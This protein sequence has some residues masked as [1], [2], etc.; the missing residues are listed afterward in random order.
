MS[1][2]ERS[3]SLLLHPLLNTTTC[4]IITYTSLLII[5][6]CSPS[7]RSLIIGPAFFSAWAYTTL[8]YCIT[9][10]NPL[11]SFLAPRMYLLVF[12][13]AD[14]VS[15]VLQAIGGGQAAVAAQKGTDT[16]KATKIS[17]FDWRHRIVIPF[18]I[19]LLSL[20]GSLPLW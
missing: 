7:P 1:L 17:E 16:K 12:V 4:C 11:C 20:R 19:R 6:L 18:Q 15:L 14:I 3:A 2:I 8:G 13:L 10:L 5:S 9:S